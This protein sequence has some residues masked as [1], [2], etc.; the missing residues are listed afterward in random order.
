[1]LSISSAWH[2]YFYVLGD[3]LFEIAETN[4]VT[5]GILKKEADNN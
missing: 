3:W 1:M 4:H 2:G 5:K